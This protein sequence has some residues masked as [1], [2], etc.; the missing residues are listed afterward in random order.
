MASETWSLQ[1]RSVREP[2]LRALSS[3]LPGQNSRN[4]IGVTFTDRLGGEEESPLGVAV[5]EAGHCDCGW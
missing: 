3:K 2:N 4:L 1:R 5:G